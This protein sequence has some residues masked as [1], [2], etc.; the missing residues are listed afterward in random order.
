MA[1]KIEKK[2]HDNEAAKEIYS[3]AQ[4]DAN[5]QLAEMREEIEAVREE[6]FGMGALHAIEANIAYNEF[7]KAMTLYRVKEGKEYRKGGMTWFE[8]CEARG[9][10]RRRVDEMLADIRS[11]ADT[12]SANFAGFCGLPFSKIR[13][14]GKQVSAES[15]QIE[16]NCLVYGDESIPLTP[17]HADDI[18]AL[19]ERISDDAKNKLE[20][21]EAQIS[22]KDKVL[23]SKQ[24]LLNKQERELKKY[25]KDAVGRGLTPS[26]DAFLQQIEN[27]KMSFDGYLMRADP[28]TLLQLVEA[29]DVTPRM[30]S[31]LISAFHYMKMQMLAAYDTAITAYGNPVMN[32]ELLEEFEKWEQAERA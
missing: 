30:R 18:Q 14:L 3:L 26:E 19:I 5:N 27:L 23:K 22:A 16:N 6:S 9:L 8:F 13:Q 4:A 21:A 32:P 2:A 1:G 12:F 20:E 7:L 25:E 10:D 28:E 17:D 15:A 31:A 11:I 24:D 29:D